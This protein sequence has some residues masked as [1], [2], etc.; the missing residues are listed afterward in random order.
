MEFQIL[1]IEF[2]SCPL[3]QSPI[4]I[5]EIQCSWLPSYKIDLSVILCSRMAPET[6][7]MEA[8][9]NDLTTHLHPWGMECSIHLEYYFRSY[10]WTSLLFFS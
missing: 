5:F 9:K 7:C 4:S 8:L 3:G 10:K 1:L 6:F 2:T